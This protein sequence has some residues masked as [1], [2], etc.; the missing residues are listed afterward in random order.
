MLIVCHMKVLNKKFYYPLKNDKSRRQPLIKLVHF[1]DFLIKK[2]KRPICMEP[3]IRT[4]NKV[5]IPL[6]K[7][8][9]LVSIV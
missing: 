5:K 4:S 7:M 3:E 2:A 1:Q 6:T 9:V 8:I